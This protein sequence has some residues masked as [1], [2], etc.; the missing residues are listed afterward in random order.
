[1]SRKRVTLG[2]TVNGE[3]Q[4]KQKKNFISDSRRLTL[5]YIVFFVWVGL[6]VFGII[7]KT[8]LRDLAIYFTSGLPVILG[9]LW[10]ETSRPTGAPSNKELDIAAIL[11]AMNNKGGSPQPQPWQPPQPIQ[12]PQTTTTTTTTQAPPQQTTQTTLQDKVVIYS[13]DSTQQ[14][15]INQSQLSTLTTM[16]YIKNAQGKYIFDIKMLSQ[17]KSLINI[18][19]GDMNGDPDI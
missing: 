6:A 11:N 15:Q 7:M 5:T 9:Y 13:N 8:D 3:P 16:G 14:M 17:I 10:A 12:Q 4:P 19:S 1:M 18:G 2:S